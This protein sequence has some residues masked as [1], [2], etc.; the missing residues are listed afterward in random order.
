MKLSLI[1]FV[2]TISSLYSANANDYEIHKFGQINPRNLIESQY[3]KGYPQGEEEDELQFGGS[4]LRLNLQRFNLPTFEIFGRHRYK[5]PLKSQVDS[6][7][8]L[9]IL[10]LIN[11]PS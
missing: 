2:A 5:G 6:P 9:K 11:D 8:T 4:A 7:G 1:L 10:P 3:E